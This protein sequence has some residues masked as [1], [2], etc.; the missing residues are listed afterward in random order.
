MNYL[1]YIAGKFYLVVDDLTPYLRMHA[2]IIISLSMIG[3]CE[4]AHLTKVAGLVGLQIGKLPETTGYD[5]SVKLGGPKEA[6]SRPP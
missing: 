3:R 6:P 5:L 4:S 1:V 2:H